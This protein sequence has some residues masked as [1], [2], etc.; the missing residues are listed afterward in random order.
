[1]WYVKRRRP[2]KA[3]FDLDAWEKRAKKATNEVQRARTKVARKQALKKHKKVYQDLKP[4]LAWLFGDRC[5]FCECSIVRNPGD[6]EHYRPK[7]EIEEN[8]KHP[9]YYWL[10]FKPENLLL[11]CED[12][13]RQF[14]K[15]RFPLE[16]GSYATSPGHSLDREQPLL[17]HP[18]IDENIED[19]IHIEV[20]QQSKAFG[21]VL[22]K[23]ARG[24]R[25]IEIYGLN[26]GRL[27]GYRSEAMVNFLARVGMEF[28]Q[29]RSLR[30][31]TDKLTN[32]QQDF[33]TACRLAFL[34][35]REEQRR[36]L[37]VQV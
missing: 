5:A 15:T 33:S 34:I 21:L 3:I 29:Q 24:E 11:S 25:S 23:S 28:S 6:V 27:P 22:A 26:E 1:M 18:C 17:L 13:N 7:S 8:P 9:G 14:K 31:M 20:D 10:A 2:P 30:P 4:Y 19:H 36:L 35:W 32:G 37:D 16:S 12:C